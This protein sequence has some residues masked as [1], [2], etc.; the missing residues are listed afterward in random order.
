M[1]GDAVLYDRLP[2]WAI[3]GLLALALI[4]V[5][6]LS[7]A[8]GQRTVQSKRY[9]QLGSLETMASGLLGLLLAFNFSI[10]QTRFDARQTLLIREADA[11]GTTYLRCSVLG[12]SDRRACREQ[13]RRYADLRIAAYGAYARAEPRTLAGALSEG[14]RI[15][16]E[17]WALV[18]HATRLDPS[19]ANALLMS[20]LNDVIDLDADRR[21]SLRIVV[22][23]AV[24]LSIM[25]VCLAWAALLGYSAGTRRSRS[26][27]AW[28]V[29][30]LLISVV[31]GVALDFDRPRSGF[32]TTSA[33][34][35]AM[36]NTVRS[37]E[38]AP[39]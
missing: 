4:A 26:A 15:Q 16:N 1:T 5:L 7:N 22:P 35:R 19:P 12:D 6:F 32:I 34:E 25:F 9:G 39:D 10:A 2:A 20:A 21:A 24:S 28:I 14:E 30:A 37:M 8:L 13:M 23:Q 18:A 31:F 11:I 36:Q 29:V 38:L 3:A 33:A 27:T 17:L